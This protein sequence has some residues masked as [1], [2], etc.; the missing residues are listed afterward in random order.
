[1]ARRGF[2]V[3]GLQR[4]LFRSARRYGLSYSR[5]GRGARIGGVLIEVV[6][7]PQWFGQGTIYINGRVVDLVHFKLPHGIHGYVREEIAGRLP[8][9]MWIGWDR[10]TGQ[11]RPA[12]G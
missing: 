3:A 4:V 5:E 8:D 11:L 6:P 2:T 9:R 7:G 10:R 12:Y 1:M